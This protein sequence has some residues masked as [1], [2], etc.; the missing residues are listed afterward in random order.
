[1]DVLIS[2]TNINSESSNSTLVS[3]IYKG[4]AKKFLH[5]IFR[6]RVGVGYS[7][8]EPT[9]L[10]HCQNTYRHLPTG[11]SRYDPYSRLMLCSTCSFI[12]SQCYARPIL[13]SMCP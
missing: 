11:R 13:Y 10:K 2:T 3:M 8:S 6:G 12:K 7:L 9:N 4:F 5:L 1:M